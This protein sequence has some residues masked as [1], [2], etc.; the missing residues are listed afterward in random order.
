V[1]L[2][3]FAAA[4]RAAAPLLLTAACD[5]YLLAPGPQQQTCISDV[6]RPDGTDEPTAARDAQTLLRIK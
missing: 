1:A 3:T 5:Q 6:R 2:P 4:C